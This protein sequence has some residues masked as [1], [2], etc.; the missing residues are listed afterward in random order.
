[1]MRDDA[2]SVA[3]EMRDAI[4]AAIGSAPPSAEALVMAMTTARELAMW[5]RPMRDEDI[6][7]HVAY[8]G[9][10][11]C[12]TTEDVASAMALASAMARGIVCD[13]RIERLAK[14][15]GQHLDD[16]ITAQWAGMADDMRDCRIDR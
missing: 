12:V 4:R 6:A 16:D 15:V 14:R 2:C 7:R 13:E 11:M 5:Y 1:M 10:E 8:M 9:S 3:I